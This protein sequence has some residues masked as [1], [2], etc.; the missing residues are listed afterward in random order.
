MFFCPSQ[1]CPL[2][3]PVLPKSFFYI[4]PPTPSKLSSPSASSHP[5]LSFS[6]SLSP[7]SF[8]S[9][10]GQGPTSLPLHPHLLSVFFSCWCNS[11]V[12]CRGHHKLT[13]SLITLDLMSGKER[14]RERRQEGDAA[15]DGDRELIF[16][17]A[18]RHGRVEGRW[19]E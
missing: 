18:W 9:I 12:R 19:D 11:T 16:I 13:R 5:A 14:G 4:P 1:F 17:F 7:M 10:R 15:R 3:S 6:L 2:Y 8:N